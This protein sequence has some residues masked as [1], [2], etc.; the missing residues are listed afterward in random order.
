[1]AARRN[2]AMAGWIG[3]R[4]HPFEAAAPGV[5]DARIAHLLGE[6]ANGDAQCVAALRIGWRPVTARIHAGAHGARC[7]L[8]LRQKGCVAPA[9]H[10]RGEVRMGVA[11]IG[12]AITEIVHQGIV[13]FDAK[14][15]TAV[16][17]PTVTTAQEIA[18]ASAD[19]GYPATPIDGKKEV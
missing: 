11:V 1:M 15:A 2:F 5:D 9:I 4:P 19:V 16:F 6:L 14:T 7:P 8:L 3:R 17:D 12:L 13:D 10:E 18:A